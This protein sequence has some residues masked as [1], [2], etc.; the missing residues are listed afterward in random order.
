MT[1]GATIGARL[2][3]SYL[4]YPWQHWFFTAAGKFETNESL[5]LV[6]RSQMAARSALV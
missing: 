5:G 3:A 4:R 2:E 6:L 1:P